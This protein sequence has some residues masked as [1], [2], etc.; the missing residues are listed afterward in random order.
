MKEIVK[1]LNWERLRLF[2][3]TVKVVQLC[4]GLVSSLP[5][6]LMEQETVVIIV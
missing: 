1:L 4:S 5:L 3:L 6:V 2:Q